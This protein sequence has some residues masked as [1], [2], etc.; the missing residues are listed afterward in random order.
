M[1]MV[2]FAINDTKIYNNNVYNSKLRR[3]SWCNGYPGRK[4]I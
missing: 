2:E 1:P 4:C 3:R